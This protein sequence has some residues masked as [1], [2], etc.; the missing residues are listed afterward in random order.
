M[1]KH[2][3]T[4]DAIGGWLQPLPP[5]VQR[6]LAEHWPELDTLA[7]ER[8][9]GEYLL[10]LEQRDTAEPLRHTAQDMRE[11]AALASKLQQR[12]SALADTQV[13]TLVEDSDF[14]PLGLDT[15]QVQLAAFAKTLTDTADALPKTHPVR[16]VE[17]LTRQLATA[18]REA[19]L[20]VTSSTKDPLFVLTNMLVETAGAPQTDLRR[21]VAR[22]AAE[23]AD[24]E[25][26]DQG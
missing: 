21:L 14:V 5:T 24:S 4:R 16:A 11:T 22:V 2:A 12:L 6:A 7:V 26:Q 1:A 8:S 10:D 17:R 19:G 18:I 15:M 25:P 20:T 23:Q 13:A 9:F 3:F